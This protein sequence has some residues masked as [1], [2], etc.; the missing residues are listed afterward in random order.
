MHK[1]L[2][3]LPNMNRNSQIIANILNQFF[4]IIRFQTA[5]SVIYMKN[6][7]AR[8]V[9]IMPVSKKIIQQRHGI[10]TA[11]D[12]QQNSGSAKISLRILQ[13]A[14]NRVYKQISDGYALHRLQSIHK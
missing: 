11:G 8:N 3:K 6:M 10:K 12:R 2:R 1:I 9:K 14:T 5:K 13:T 7:Q 4:I